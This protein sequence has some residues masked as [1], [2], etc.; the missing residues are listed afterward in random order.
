ML[1]VGA[2]SHMPRMVK[3]DDL[4]AYLESSECL[5]MVAGWDVGWWAAQLGLFLMGWAQAAYRML[6]HT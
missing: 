6:L 4:E 1:E 3:E 5:A 2:M